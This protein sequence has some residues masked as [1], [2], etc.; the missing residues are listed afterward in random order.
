MDKATAAAKANVLGEIITLLEKAREKVGQYGGNGIEGRDGFVHTPA[1]WLDGAM[2]GF[3]TSY[4]ILVAYARA[5][6]KGGEEPLPAARP[7]ARQVRQALDPAM[8]YNRPGDAIRIDA[9]E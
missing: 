5:E 1:A 7:R 6:N 9:I 3:V 4:S 2:D 8:F